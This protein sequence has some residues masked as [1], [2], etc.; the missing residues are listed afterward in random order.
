VQG[1]AALA[2]NHISALLADPPLPASETDAPPAMP[3]PITLL[4]LLLRH[5]LQLEY[6]ATAARLLS[7]QPGGLPVSAVLREREL[8]NLN[9][10]T[11]VTTWRML[12]GRPSPATGGVAPAAF[13]KGVAKFDEPDLKP[14]GE[15]RAALAHLQRLKPET[16]ELLLTGAL[17]VT[18]HR[19]DAWV[20]SLASRRLA[21]M[22]AQQPTGLRLGGY[23]WVLNLKPIGKGAPVATP[24]AETGE[25]FARAD[26]TGFVHA[27]SVAQAQTAALLRNA[28]LTHSRADAQD[29]FA[30]DLSSRRI[31]LATMLLDGVR[32][33]QPLGALLGYVFERRL[34]ELKLDDT[35]DDFR[36]LAPLAAVNAVPNTQPAESHCGPTS[37]GGWVT[38]SADSFRRWRRRAPSR[39]L[40]PTGISSPRT[41]ISTTPRSSSST[42]TE[43][44]SL[45]RRATSGTSW[46]KH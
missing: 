38:C 13:L 19:I 44:R 46:G 10:A 14:L 16:L 28:H 26:D 21:A 42:S 24:E 45:R 1:V 36:L 40:S 39:S 37:P 9:A 43:P 29:L 41:S 11:A 31:R 33:G 25:V 30:V 35:I 5:S 15:L 8:V 4:H 6:T 22:R 2:P 3:A 18:S 17:D 20:T 7:R 32:Q 12:L 23:G 27:P 34:H